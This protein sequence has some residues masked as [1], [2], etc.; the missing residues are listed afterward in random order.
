MRH[1]RLGT[2][3][4]PRSP[5]GERRYSLPKRHKERY[6]NPRS[7]HEERRAARGRKYEQHGDF[8]PRSPHGERRKQPSTWRESAISIHAPRTGSDRRILSATC[9]CIIS[10]HAPRTGSDAC[11]TSP[12]VG[13][14]PFQSTLPARGATG[15]WYDAWDS[16]ADFNPCSPH[17]ERRIA[18]ATISDAALFQSTLP[19]RGATFGL[20]YDTF[21]MLI[22]IHAPRTGSDQA[23]TIEM[24]NLGHISIHAPRTGS[25]RASAAW[26]SSQLRISIHA[27]RTGSDLCAAHQAAYQ[28]ISIHA[29]RTGSDARASDCVRP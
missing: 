3:F 24:R 4:N 10:I 22:S 12:T 7:P 26:S 25:D 27:P 5:H 11:R 23:V 1:Q 16:G 9:G 19:A 20:H 28:H 18:R 13:R 2:N 15:D 29:P 17:G 6:F 8:N 14:L 21:R